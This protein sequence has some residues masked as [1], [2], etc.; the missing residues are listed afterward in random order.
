M[1][2]LE[3]P[4]LTYDYILFKIREVFPGA[5][6]EKGRQVG[7]RQVRFWVWQF[8]I[9]ISLCEEK[10]AVVDKIGEARC[11]F[12]FQPE[13]K[14][15]IF[16]KTATVKNSSGFQKFLDWTLAYLGGVTAAISQSMEKAP[17]MVA[18]IFGGSD[19]R[20]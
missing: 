5:E 10:V 17:D 14:K 20:E 15:P 11:T 1:P 4:D 7:G 13:N 3:D 12:K 2:E 18:D 16:T 8:L 19:S 6:L 9:E